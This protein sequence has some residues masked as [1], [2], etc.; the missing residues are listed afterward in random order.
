MEIIVA[1]ALRSWAVE[2][3]K[4]NLLKV[5]DS[6]ETGFTDLLFENPLDTRC[7]DSLLQLI[8]LLTNG[9][10]K[11]AERISRSR[12]PSTASCIL[13]GHA[14]EHQA[15]RKAEVCHVY[16]INGAALEALYT[17]LLAFNVQ[18]LLIDFGD[19]VIRSFVKL[20]KKHSNFLHGIFHH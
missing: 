2:E 6:L 3:M 13:F 10:P 8:A 18:S 15:L 1:M 12:L 9:S 16:V 20:F 14:D 4:T 5:C 19:G 11:C 7:I 17:M